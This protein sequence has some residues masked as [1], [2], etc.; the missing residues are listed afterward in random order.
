MFTIALDSALWLLKATVI[1]PDYGKI[2]GCAD[3]L[4]GICKTLNSLI[5]ISKIF[6][7]IEKGLLLHL[8]MKKTILIPLAEKITPKLT[9]TI[10]QF[11]LKCIP[12]WQNIQISDNGCYLGFYIG[13]GATLTQNWID[14]IVGW[15]AVVQS[16]IAT[17]LTPFYSVAAYNC[18]AFSKLAYQMQMLSAIPC[19][20]QFERQYLHGILR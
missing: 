2:Y 15:D 9:R 17:T 20:Q 6:K 13:P 1:Q 10:R 7:L 18:R 12:Q 3:D 16:I 8:N 11:L 19:L 14:P 4:A 5:D